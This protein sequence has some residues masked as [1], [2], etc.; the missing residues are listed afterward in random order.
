MSSSHWGQDVFGVETWPYYGEID[1]N[2]GLTVGAPEYY[3]EGLRKR[4]REQAEKGEEV[5]RTFVS[6][7]DNARPTTWGLEYYN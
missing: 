7:G 3:I 5:D 1:Q 6:G 4:K 2:S